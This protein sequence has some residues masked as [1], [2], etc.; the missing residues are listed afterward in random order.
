MRKRICIL[1]NGEILK[2]VRQTVEFAAASVKK[3]PDL[4]MKYLPE[5]YR[6]FFSQE[7]DNIML[8]AAQR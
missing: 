1:M 7:I 2:G 4:A 3:R 8:Y 5:D 6:N